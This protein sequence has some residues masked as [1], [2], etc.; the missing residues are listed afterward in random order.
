MANV[1]STIIWIAIVG[2]AIGTY[3]LRSVFL[4]G[5]QRLG[6][7]PPAISTVLRFVPIAVFA[8]L[9]TPDLAYLDGLLVLS[10][11]NEQLMAGLVAFV[12]AWYTE[13]ML[14]TV[15]V[16]MAVLWFLQWI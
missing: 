12:V 16:G 15:G 4:L 3:I 2:I 7:I 8:A 1:D 9:I 11:R 13:N 10:P 14:L 5:I 6:D